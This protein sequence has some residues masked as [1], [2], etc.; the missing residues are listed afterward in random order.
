MCPPVNT[1]VARFASR[2]HG[3]VTRRELLAAGVTTDEGRR[4]VRGGLL[5]RVYPGV[6][7][8]G[9]LAPSVE[10]RYLGA[11]KACGSGAVLS[12]RAAAHLWGLVRGA[13]PPPEVSAATLKRIPGITTRRVKRI[14]RT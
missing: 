5:I 1:V 13:A 12:G 9:H 14:H 10:A 11:V 6:Y 2:A 3:V 8:V 4:G 7:R